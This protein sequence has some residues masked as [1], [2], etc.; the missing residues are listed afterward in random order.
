MTLN[1][2]CILDDAN[3]FK[4]IQN[5]Y[6]VLLKQK[7]RLS[8]TMR[9]QI[10]LDISNLMNAVHSN[11]YLDPDLLPDRIYFDKDG[12]HGLCIIEKDDLIPSQSTV[13]LEK[14][15]QF[16]PPELET[17]QPYSA[18]SDVYRYGIVLY[19]LI[20]SCYPARL[21]LGPELNHCPPYLKDLLLKCTA[22]TP[23]HRYK[24][25]EIFDILSTNFL[26]FDTY[27]IGWAQSCTCAFD[28]L[29]NPTR[30]SVLLPHDKNGSMHK[31]KHSW[32]S[33][34]VASP[35]ENGFEY[36]AG[37]LVF[38][39]IYNISKESV[40]QENEETMLE[41]T[42]FA[43]MFVDR[44]KPNKDV[45]IDAVTA[46]FQSWGDCISS[47][48]LDAALFQDFQD[49]TFKTIENSLLSAIISFLDQFLVEDCN[50]MIAAGL[51]HFEG[52]LGQVDYEFAAYWFEEA[53]AKY[54]NSP[55]AS[56][57]LGLLHLEGLGT[58][59]NPPESVKLLLEAAKN[60]KDVITDL[61]QAYTNGLGIQKNT[62]KALWWLMKCVKL[63]HARSQFLLGQWYKAGNLVKK[64]YAKVVK[65][66]RMAAE[67]GDVEAQYHFA[68]FLENGEGNNENNYEAFRWYYKAAQKGYIK[69]TNRVGYCFEKGIGVPQDHPRAL[70]FYRE[71]AN[72][73][74]A[75]SQYNLGLCYMHGIGVKK[76]AGLAVEWFQNSAS[77]D[78]ALAHFQ[79]GKCFEE[80]L[81][82]EKDAH[83]A[84]LCYK[85]AKQ[86][87]F[88][89]KPPSPKTADSQI[90]KLYY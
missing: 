11:G 35:I 1:H 48:T 39:Q 5:T 78:I 25:G 13:I 8:S 22:S 20:F 28:S 27:D 40:V 69:A 90:F 62:D 3:G 45:D 23:A 77:Q 59:K 46:L 57:C 19:Y 58:S 76:N 68:K 56:I 88:V 18:A 61:V 24:F 9:Y 73:G 36:S 72:K 81:G 30:I 50:G 10:A 12:Q 55:E 49:I 74:Y 64:D 15:E 85:K 7:E 87:G 38:L 60:G 44:F 53:L 2:P 51:R 70:Q 65:L 83:K 82:V 86:L 84:S 33:G 32:D 47:N 52:T 37:E 54:P 66:Y 16:Q 43:K 89:D 80:G 6:E 71:A 31:R 17:G 21:P 14:D 42:H 75:A 26:E 67:G 4:T 41:S 79:L 29:M 63:N 34:I